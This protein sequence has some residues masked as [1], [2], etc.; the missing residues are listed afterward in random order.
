[1]DLHESLL[2]VKCV[3]TSAALVP[4]FVGFSCFHSGPIAFVIAGAI[5]QSSP[6]IVASLM[7]MI[8][9]LAFSII[10]NTRRDARTLIAAILYVCSG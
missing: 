7:L 5:R 3:N 9:A 2:V 6:V 4:Q 10:G 1:M 8:T